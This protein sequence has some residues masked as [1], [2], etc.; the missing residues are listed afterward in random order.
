MDNESSIVL[1]IFEYM[2]YKYQKKIEYM[3]HGNLVLDRGQGD[4]ELRAF[5]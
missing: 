5:D 2:H 3:R 4:L 1:M